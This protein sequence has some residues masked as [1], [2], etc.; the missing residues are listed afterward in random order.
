VARHTWKALI[1]GPLPEAREI[2][3]RSIFHEDFPTEAT[4]VREPA[5]FDDALAEQTPPD[6][7]LIE[8][9][10]H[11]LDVLDK[12]REHY[13]VVPLVM[14][15]NPES[16]S[17]LIEALE[18]G[19]ERYVM[20][21]EN[22]EE[23]VEL[24][25]Q[26][27][28][29]LLQR[30]VEPPSMDEPSAEQMHRYAQ[31]HHIL[32]PFFVV[33]DR[34]RLL[35]VN[36]AGEQLIWKLIGRS[37]FIGEKLADELF[38][39]LGDPFTNQL[40]DAFEGRESVIQYSFDR[41]ETPQDRNV[42][43]TP[44]TTSSGRVIAA[45]ISI[46]QEIPPEVE[47]ARTMR[48]ISRFAGGLAHDFNNL[49]NVMMVQTELLG[50]HLGEV[51][52]PVEKCLASM[53]RAVSEGSELTRQLLAVSHETLSYRTAIRLNELLEALEPRL[54][55]ML[56]GSQS[57]EMELSDR[58]PTV[59][60]DPQQMDQLVSN[61][62]E[63]AAD[64]LGRDGSITIRTSLVA[65]GQPEPI[66]RGLESRR[67]VA[68]IVE[69][70]GPGVRPELHTR[71]FEPFYTT[72][73]AEGHSG[74]GLTL[75][76]TVVEQVGGRIYID[77]EPGEGFVVTVFLPAGDEAELQAQTR[78]SSG[79]AV[80][81]L[82]AEESAR[83][84]LLLVEDED[85]LRLPFREALIQRGFNVLEARD[86]TSARDLIVEHGKDIEV[87]VS[88]V[89]MP[90]G[91]GVELVQE[92]VQ[93]HP[94]IKV[95]FVSGYTAEVI[96]DPDGELDID[97][98]FVAKPVSLR[99]LVDVVDSLVDDGHLTGSKNDRSTEESTDDKS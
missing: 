67:W 62:V 84:T 57:L 95:V 20:R 80:E 71:I 41:L 63:N 72:R 99:R 35:Y 15:S 42:H 30:T 5:D 82:A 54:R 37:P 75:V 24:L 96:G 33:D 28:F 94:E 22:T 19:L 16:A 18:K 86:I 2:F 29:R 81:E 36:A 83:T 56:R 90:G 14:V 11:G 13:P 6:V 91:S 87:V 74:L 58:L 70:T 93:E 55:Q 9:D 1:L 38:R 39:G 46:H 92:L 88:D 4:H 12:V 26:V 10:P 60:A 89:V 73:R 76:H 8:A 97:Y 78:E 53:G 77:S 52:K 31:Y 7:I 66:P 43:C 25:S 98:T 49:L 23:F 50:V 68:L 32:H 64:A 45:S 79:E 21:I 48:A 65:P 34:E 61:L 51:S 27:V 40:S 85:E 17:V 44:V 47:R 69:D 3:T 59:Q